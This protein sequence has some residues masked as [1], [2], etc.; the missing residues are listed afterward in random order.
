[1]ATPTSVKSASGTVIV[2]V[3]AVVSQTLTNKTLTSP[4][5]NFSSNGV[6]DLIYRNGS[7]ITD[8]LAIG[9]TDQILAVQAQITYS[10]TRKVYLWTCKSFVS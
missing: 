2:R 1:M 10:V 5:I 3:V 4:Q 7:G 6:G 9:S 8:R